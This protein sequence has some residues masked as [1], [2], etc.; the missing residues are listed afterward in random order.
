MNSILKYPKFPIMLMCRYFLILVLLI[1]CG[2][3]SSKKTEP[4]NSETTENKT[5]VETVETNKNILFFGDSLTAG[6]GLDDAND[7]FPAIIQSKIDSLGL[8]YKVINSGVSGETSSGGL[9]RIEWVLN[10]KVDVFVLEL[11]ANDGLRGIQLKQTRE[12]LQTIINK[13]RKTYPKAS[14]ILAGMQ[15]P[16]NLG[17]EY[18]E[19]FRTMFNELAETNKVDLI[20][21]LLKD[22]GGIAELNLGDG[23]HPNIE[24]QK[25]VA[26]NV[27]E[28]LETVLVR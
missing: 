15:L 8:S 10:Q 11:G 18:T 7:A 22:V 3:E 26:N 2:G 5:S 14:I 28:I 19:E 4:T 1:S 16:P 27:W 25:I 20:P 21:F 13:V 24:G 23:I 17:Q 6:F 9:G 12:N